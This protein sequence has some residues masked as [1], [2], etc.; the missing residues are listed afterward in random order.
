M[1]NSL[2]SFQGH[3]GL[4]GFS[5]MTDFSSLE[6]QDSLS[7]VVRSYEERVNFLET[8]IRRISRLSNGSDVDQQLLSDLQ[9]EVD[10]LSLENEELRCA[11]VDSQNDT[12]VDELRIE[13]SELTAKNVRQEAKLEMLEAVDIEALREQI[14]RLQ[15]ENNDLKC[16]VAIFNA[17]GA[18]IIK[19]REENTE[20]KEKVKE[21]DLIIEE[22]NKELD[23]VSGV[24][25]SNIETINNAT[26]PG[27]VAK[28][29]LTA[30]QLENERLTQKI[31]QLENI[32]IEKMQLEAEIKLLK[33]QISNIN[34]RNS[35]L[36]E[37]IEELEIEND[38]LANQVNQLGRDKRNSEFEISRLKNSNEVFEERISTLESEQQES[39]DTISGLQNQ[40]NQQRNELNSL[41][42]TIAN[43]KNDLKRSEDELNRRQQEIDELR[44]DNEGL[45]D[46]FRDIERSKNRLNNE[47]DDLNKQIED[48]IIQL[49]KE[50]QETAGGNNGNGNNGNNG[51][52]NNGNGNNTAQTDVVSLRKHFSIIIRNL[53]GQIKTLQQR[54]YD[55]E[56][57]LGLTAGNGQNKRQFDIKVN[58]QKQ[59]FGRGGSSGSG[60]SDIQDII[61]RHSRKSCSSGKCGQNRNGGLLIGN[62]RY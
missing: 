61:N 34:Q 59:S 10:R 1:Q 14:D 30:L 38:D 31:F 21:L 3:G 22:L 40:L 17:Q 4:S 24:N 58:V 57:Q 60:S 19:Y 46:K 13:L 15:Q 8:E 9:C 32:R 52:G 12:L 6:D 29:S 56:G 51:N 55:L 27:V 54:I 20:L 16:E 33:N 48:L 62:S 36:Q 47:I 41:N 42:M 28:D 18:D 43:L 53:Q 23:S 45:E 37:S 49:D 39:N 5:S 11:L 50:S 2:S 35:E 25:T 7:A 26:K 44:T